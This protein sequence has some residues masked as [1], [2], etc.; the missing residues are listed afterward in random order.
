MIK[1][2]LVVKIT[3]GGELVH[4]TYN[5]C[6]VI[7]KNAIDVRSVTKSLI[8]FDGTGKR[9]LFVKHLGV[10]GYLIC[11]I[12]AA[13]PGTGRLGDNVAAWIHIPLQVKVE[14]STMSSIISEIDEIISNSKGIDKERLTNV[15]GKEYQKFDRGYSSAMSIRSSQEGDFGV[16]YY[17]DATPFGL[18][19]LLGD[20]IYQ[21][22]YRVYKGVFFADR[23]H[24]IEASS[25]GIQMKS[26]E[27]NLRLKKLHAIQPVPAHDDFIPYW[28]GDVKFDKH[29][30]LFDG[31]KLEIVWKRLNYENIDKSVNIDSPL[32]ICEISKRLMI[33]R[34][35]YRRIFMRS[36]FIVR[37]PNSRTINNCVI[38]LNNRR[39]N[40][41]LSIPEL[42]PDQLVDVT[43]TADKYENYREKRNLGNN[44]SFNLKPSY[45]KYKFDFKD[46]GIEG[47][48]RAEL[49]IE[50]PDE[51]TYFPIEGYCLK[52]GKA[53]SLINGMTYRVRRDTKKQMLLCL[54]SGLVGCLATL[55]IVFVLLLSMN[56]SVG[57]LQFQMKLPLVVD[58]AVKEV[59]APENGNPMNTGVDKDSV[60][61]G[62]G[63]LGADA[64]ASSPDSVPPVGSQ[65][66][67][68][69]GGGSTKES[70]DGKLKDM[71]GPEIGEPKK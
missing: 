55:I 54:A 66:G 38:T 28:K 24:G 12:R 46:C 62:D 22:D 59:K 13:S 68:S 7:N 36:Q 58:K 42:E 43:I 41:R 53:R 9:V 1:L 11:L 29:V 30:E 32:D 3:S 26:V 10:D 40:E 20:A 45:N 70:E 5:E 2:G 63:A 33:N 50:S 49:I 48:K 16:V 56:V 52:T 18:E 47:V 19:D 4:S 61:I 65:T 27:L 37:G 8:D 6:S 25:A 51:L 44:N 57:D 21:P 69:Q 39:L 31:E 67:N 35:E 60:K 64:E 71:N 17:G 14:S 23:Q 15:M 34:L